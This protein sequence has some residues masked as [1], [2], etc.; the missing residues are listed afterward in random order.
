MGT[1]NY[2]DIVTGAVFSRDE[3]RILTWGEDGTARPW[4]A[5]TDKQ[6]GRRASNET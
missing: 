1:I 2:R 3:K 6:A 5:G 4:K